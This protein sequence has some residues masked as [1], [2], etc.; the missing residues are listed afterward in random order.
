MRAEEFLGEKWSDWKGLAAVGAMNAAV[1]GA[2]YSGHMSDWM[3]DKQISAQQYPEQQADDG[4][5]DFSTISVELPD[6][7]PAK[8]DKAPE[9]QMSKDAKLLAL[10]MWGEARGE[11]AKGMLA[12][13]HVIKNRMDSDRFG[14]SVAHVVWRPKQFSCWNKHDPNR[15]KM[16]EIAALPKDSVE[17]K[18]WKLAKRLAN[19]ILAGRTQDPTDGALFYHTTGIK[20][21][22]A[23]ASKAVAQ[24]ANHVFYRHDIGKAG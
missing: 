10:T 13:G 17:Y 8:D 5:Q 20:P 7:A 9:T 21:F 19:Q 18:R 14:G 15:E 12:V 3:S 23:D 16:K 1:A 24:I 22:W 2:N 6:A 11:G 4:N